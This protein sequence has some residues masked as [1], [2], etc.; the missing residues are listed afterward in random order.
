MSEGR[1]ILRDGIR[2][3]TVGC[4]GCLTFVLIGAIVFFAL[5]GWGEHELAGP[6]PKPVT[7]ELEEVRRAS[8]VNDE[9]RRRCEERDIPDAYCPSDR[10]HAS[11]HAIVECGAS[12]CGERL[13]GVET[14]VYAVA[15]TRCGRGR[16]VPLKHAGPQL[17]R[18]E[19]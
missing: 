2:L 13:D 12:A 15:G 9:L 14:L 19:N 11:P 7:S 3:G 10:L 6:R 18:C 17:Y 5:I 4:V 1:S 8:T 16:W